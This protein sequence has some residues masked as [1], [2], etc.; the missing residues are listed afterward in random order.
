MSLQLVSALR[1]LAERRP[2]FHS[3]AD[4]QFA[5]AWQ[6]RE[7]CPEWQLR[8]EYPFGEH[9]RQALDI[10]LRRGEEEVG[11]EL[12]YLTHRLDAVVE[13]ERF[14]LKEG[15]ARDE[16]QYKAVDDIRRMESFVAA[17]K[18]A[19]AFVVLLTNHRSVWTY[20]PRFRKAAAFSLHEGR[21]LAGTLAFTPDTA[22]STRR[23]PITLRARYHI[24]W[25]KYSEIRPAAGRGR[26]RF[27]IF[28]IRRR[29]LGL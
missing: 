23:P 4:F 25:Q 19:S 17:R 15:S 18:R 2:V 21:E 28:E 13:G 14:R 9:A 8:L 11:I 3:E 7:M 22:D 20:S 29:S 12:K 26:F 6:I 16:D 1:A 10:L 27:A 24:T 5:L